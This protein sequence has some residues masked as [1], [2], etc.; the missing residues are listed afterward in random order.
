M[1]KLVSLKTLGVKRSSMLKKFK[2]AD[3]FSDSVS[4]KLENL[5]SKQ[6]DLYTMSELKFLVENLTFTE[7][8][9]QYLEN[10]AEWMAKGVPAVRIYYTAVNNKESAKEILSV[11]SKNGLKDETPNSWKKDKENTKEKPKTNTKKPKIVDKPKSKVTKK[12]KS[13]EKPKRKYT[14]KAKS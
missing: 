3:C 12:P 11:L 2:D 7:T 8:E 10:P 14:K 1:E 13:D 9:K 4:K 5:L 6:R